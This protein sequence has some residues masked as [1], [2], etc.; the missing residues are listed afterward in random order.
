MPLDAADLA[1]VR[2]AHSPLQEAVESLAVL[3]DTTAGPY[4]RWAS[5]VTPGLAALRLPML[6][7]LS[8]HRSYWPDFLFPAPERLGTSFGTELERMRATPTDALRADLDKVHANQPL[9]PALLRCY[10]APERA[11]GALA[12]ELT[13]YWATCIEPIWPRLR[14]LVDADLSYRAAGLT[15]GGFVR[16]L[17]DLHPR[18]DYGE[19]ALR[20]HTPRWDYRTE[21]RGAG[22]LLVPCVFASN[23]VLVTNADSQPM[24]SYGPRGLGALWSRPATTRMAPLANLLGRSRAVLLAHTDLPMST[25]QL[26]AMLGLTAAA[27]SQHLSVLHKSGLVTRQRSGRAVLY[28]RTPLATQL[29]ADPPPTDLP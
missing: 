23:R 24:V 18:L 6:R 17:G 22:L 29:I 19:G 5:K 14:A 11:L 9:A 16:L 20:V 8:R 26:A 28:Q 10:D 15:A 3:A 7:A 12:D 2:F 1:R 25:T 27:V 13:A 4:H 21:R